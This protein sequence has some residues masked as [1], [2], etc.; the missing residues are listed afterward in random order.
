M[1]VLGPAKTFDNSKPF[2]YRD[3]NGKLADFN[4]LID[5]HLLLVLF[6]SVTITMDLASGSW[7]IVFWR[8]LCSISDPSI[9][10]ENTDEACSQ[11]FHEWP[12]YEEKL[13][14]GRMCT[15]HHLKQPYCYTPAFPQPE[16]LPIHPFSLHLSVSLSYR[17]ILAPFT[18]RQPASWPR[19][20]VTLVFINTN[21]FRNNYHQT[22]RG[23]DFGL[24]TYVKRFSVATLTAI[25]NNSYTI[26]ARVCTYIIKEIF[27]MLA[28]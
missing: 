28:W 21:I 25:R 19:R 9:L 7:F 27:T 15:P 22:F 14:H 13:A 3:N 20:S 5:Y 18:L 10:D 11:R 6:Y 16:S 1:N 4:Q 8:T 17:A 26:T 12:V 24:G 2:F 23:S